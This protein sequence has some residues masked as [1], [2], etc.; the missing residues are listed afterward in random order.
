MTQ[1]RRLPTPPE[2]ALQRPEY[3]L[4]RPESHSALHRS[5]VVSAAGAAAGGFASYFANLFIGGGAGAQVFMGLSAAG[6]LAAL[7][8]QQWPKGGLRRIGQAGL[9]G[10]VGSLVSNLASRWAPLSAALFGLAA[11]PILGAGEPIKRRLLTGFVAAGFGF[12]GLHVGAAL[13]NA[14][15]FTGL[16]PGPLAAAAAGATAGLFIGLATAPR[17]LIVGPHPVD[18]AYGQA[19]QVRD[20]EIHELLERALRLHQSLRER[21]D[22]RREM[23]DLSLEPRVAEQVLK[24]LEIAEHCRQVDQEVTED[25]LNEIDDRMAEVERKAQASSD[26]TAQKTYMKALESL[27]D[28]QEALRRLGEGRERVVARLHVHVAL[29]EKLRV[30]VLQIRSADAERFGTEDS[31]VMEAV[32]ELGRELDATAHAISE[33]FG[34]PPA[35]VASAG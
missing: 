8:Y 17:H 4:T 35:L 32:E 11:M 3:A 7:A 29:L 12:A 23:Q 14:G 19:L 15:A 31:F 28:Q 34:Q 10:A 1:L 27:Q 5:A 30:S 9:L 25:R 33:V 13:L 16:V 26:L 21:S 18:E 6:A 2:A 20:G 22:D 24:I